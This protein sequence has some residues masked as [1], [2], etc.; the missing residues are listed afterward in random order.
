MHVHVPSS[1]S[2]AP[3]RTSSAFGNSLTKSF[4][5]GIEPPTP[6]NAV[7]SFQISLKFFTSSVVNG[8]S[9]SATTPEPFE[10]GIN[11]TDAF[12]GTFFHNMFF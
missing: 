8:L 12:H 4:A 1:S 2:A 10:F 3:T 6:I 9:G 7:S 11:F 5:K